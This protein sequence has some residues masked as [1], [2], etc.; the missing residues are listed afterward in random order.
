MRSARSTAALSGSV[1]PVIMLYVNQ[2]AIS[3]VKRVAAATA[4][5]CRRAES[6]D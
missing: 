1:T 2:A 4:R 5:L 3:S 6:I